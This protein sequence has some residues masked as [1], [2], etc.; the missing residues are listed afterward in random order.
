MRWA[1]GAILGISLNVTASEPPLR[2]AVADSW[3]MPMVQIERGRPTQGILYDMMLSLATQVGVPAQ[4]HVLPRAR[5]Q[6]AMEHGEVDVRCYAAQSWLPNQSGDYIWSIPVLFQ[7]D[8]LISRP[9]PPVDLDPASLAR[10]PIGT[11]LGYTYPTLQPLFDA[12]QLQREDAR[13]Q[14]QVLEKLLAGRYRYAVSNQ[15]TLDWFNQRLLP[16]QQLQRVAVL[17]EQNVGCYVRNDPNVP[18]Q[19]ILRTLLRMKMSGEIDE[20]IRLYTGSSESSP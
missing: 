16:G 8:L 13:N 18:V 9:G 15:W 3:A 2:F 5:V 10:Q 1:L 6:S 14:E 4:F 12:D 20:I 7:R 11:V 17:Q 19:R